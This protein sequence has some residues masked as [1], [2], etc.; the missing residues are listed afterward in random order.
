[1]TMSGSSSSAS[2]HARESA[3]RLTRDLDVGD[4]VERGGQR[5]AE[6]RVVIDDEDAHRLS[7]SVHEVHC[8][9]GGPPSRQWFRLDSFGA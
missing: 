1:M 8:G 3:A 5:P 9:R 6:R 4:E 7:L 2:V